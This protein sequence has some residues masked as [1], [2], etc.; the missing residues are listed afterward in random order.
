MKMVIAIVVLS[1]LL[2]LSVC[3]SFGLRHEIRKYQEIKRKML[4]EEL[5]RAKVRAFLRDLDKK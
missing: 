5:Y 3:L 4:E 2:A 1:I